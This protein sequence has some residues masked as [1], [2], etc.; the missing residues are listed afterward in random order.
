MIER[1]ATLP[2]VGDEYR[3][4]AIS[5]DGETIAFQ[6]YAGGDWHIYLVDARGGEPRAAAEGD[7]ACSSPLFSRDGRSL[8]FARDDKGSERFEYCRLD[9][10]S[11]E[12]DCLL[13]DLRG[14]SPLPDFDLS[15]DGRTLAFAVNHDVSYAV[16]SLAVAAP[17]AE[18]ALHILVD[19]YANDWSPRWSPDGRCL[20]WQAETHGQDSAVFILEVESGSLTT[21]GGE[22]PLQAAG[23][24]WSPDGH[25]IAFHGGPFDHSGIGLYDVGSATVSW[26]WANEQ[27]AHAAAWSPDGRALAFVL[28][29][30][31]ETSLW[32]VDLVTQTP[33]CLSDVPGTHAAPEFTPDGTAVVFVHSRPGDPAALW[34]VELTDGTTTRITPELPPEVAAVPF[35]SGREVWYTSRDR[36]TEVPGLYCEPHEANGAGVVMI[37][38]GPTWHHANGW[39]PLRQALLAAGVA[40]L[41]PNYRGSDGYGRR[42]QLANRFLIGQGEVQDCAAAGDFLVAHGC[43]P[44]RIGVTSRSH[45]GYLTMA[46][47]WQSPEL[48][49]CGVAGVPFFDHIDAQVDPAI[50]EDLRWWDRE[51]VGD[52]ERDHDRLTYYSPI[53]HL[54]RVKAPVLLL[55][56]ANDVRCPPRQIGEVLQ[57][58]R[59]QGTEAE[60]HIYPDE[61][62]GVTQFANRLDYD[63]RTLQFLFDH[64][65]IEAG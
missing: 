55:A 58:L 11:G 61:G 6:W 33:R 49:A 45:G 34:R 22:Q 62:H 21:I 24:A 50:R 65:G 29:E 10:T 26:A 59:A 42:W 23:P 48:W 46:C 31:V 20:A 18:A 17:P 16:A 39:D 7:D 3:P 41:S 30:G 4:F 64:L 28:D 1:L 57:R 47:L 36:L 44:D 63:R 37:H 14:R 25:T 51:N 13:G 60:A 43:D 2:Q 32:H 12:L 8:Y 19:H 35:V 5:P 56:G 38:G 15:P 52:L 54:D 40:V 27:G 9:L 53:N